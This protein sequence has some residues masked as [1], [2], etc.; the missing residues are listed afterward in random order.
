MPS[1]PH[2]SADSSIEPGLLAQFAASSRLEALARFEPAT[3][4]GPEP[5]AVGRVHS[6]E[7][8]ESILRIEQE[9]ACDR[10][11]TRRNFVSHGAANYGLTGHERRLSGTPDIHVAGPTMF[12]SRKM[13]HSPSA[14]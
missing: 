8:K 10:T 14:F 12:A 7:E 3:G 6:F 2:P 11:R 1:R 13:T 5:V 9:D 4:R